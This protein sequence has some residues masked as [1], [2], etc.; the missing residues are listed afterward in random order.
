MVRSLG[1]TLALLIVACSNPAEPPAI[2]TPN[3]EPAVIEVPISQ[4]LLAAHPS[5]IWM[6]AADYMAT[7]DMDAATIWFYA[8]QLRFRV[9]MDCPANPANPQD[10]IV[11]SAQFET[12][13]PQI[14][15]WAAQNL[16]R[17]VDILDAV[18]AWDD[19]NAAHPA[20]YA[21]CEQTRQK[22][23]QTYENIRAKAEAR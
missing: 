6:Q 2:K 17:F 8:G 9:L 1:I 23:R 3:P 18:L 11:F 7:G 15:G 4:N 5:K 10:M 20:S 12:M 16:D 13:E 21:D 19:E 14:N 22:V